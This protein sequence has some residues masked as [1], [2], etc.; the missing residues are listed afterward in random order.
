MLLVVAAACGLL[1]APAPATRHLAPAPAARH[2]LPGLPRPCTPLRA[3][4]VAAS[5]E[6]PLDPRAALDE[7]GTL[8][9]KVRELWTDGSS[10]SAEERA[11]RQRELVDQYFR[12]F[13]PAV[14]FS[15]VQLGLSLAAFGTL[16]AALNLSHRG[17]DDV[18]RLAE[19]FA[20][21]APLVDAINPTLGNAA[22]ALAGVELLAPLLIAASLAAA[23]AA[24]ASLKARLEG[25][26]LPDRL[27]PPTD[28]PPA[29]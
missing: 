20:P 28:P 14:A 17:Y 21:L 15:G 9:E 7:V 5:E 19:A 4:V 23:P 18:A 25:W 13:V 11:V 8:L 3:G 27:L 22:I 16:L 12:V 26:G 24:A 29:S 2:S 10:W 1:L 6:A